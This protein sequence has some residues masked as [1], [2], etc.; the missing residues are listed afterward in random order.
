[1]FTREE[2]LVDEFSQIIARGKLAYASPM[3]RAMAR[4]ANMLLMRKLVSIVE[5]GVH[6]AIACRGL[7]DDMVKRTDKDVL[8]CT[9]YHN[10]L[11]LIGC[12]SKMVKH[13]RNPVTFEFFVYEF[14]MSCMTD[15]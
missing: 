14:L 9:M 4:V 7:A 6:P 3:N 13:E 2:L 1:M 8:C 11:A 5:G 10:Q 12:F 15:D